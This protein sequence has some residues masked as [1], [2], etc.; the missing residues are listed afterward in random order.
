MTKTMIKIALALFDLDGVVFNTES[1]YTDFYQGIGKEFRPDIPDF[2]LKIKGQTLTQIYDRWFPGQKELQDEITRRLNA[3]ESQMDYPFVP[4]FVPFIQK[5]KATGIKTAIVTSSN[6][7]KMACVYKV[8]PELNELFDH[9]FTA[10]DFKFSKPDP[11]PYLTAIRYFDISAENTV[12][13]EDSVNGLKSAQSSGCF[14]VGL[15]T[16]NPVKTVNR[17][18]HKTIRDFTNC[19]ISD[20]FT[21]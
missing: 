5:L 8:R 2:A 17:Y 4:G 13:F 10:E 21:L 6:R 16:T 1:Q 12:I 9:V 7:P 11:D 3:F 19:E 18:A 20:T 15:T 14:V